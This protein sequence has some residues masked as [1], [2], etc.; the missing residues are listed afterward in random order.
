[1]GV[2]EELLAQQPGAAAGGSGPVEQEDDLGFIGM[3]KGYVPTRPGYGGPVSPA[4]A[5]R[6]AAGG[7]TR[8]PQITPPRYKTGAE[9]EPRSYSPEMIARLQQQL[10]GAGLI[11]PSTRYRLGVWD[12]TSVNAYKQLLGYA[13]Q[14]GLSREDALQQLLT[15]PQLKG[16]QAVGEDGVMGGGGSAGPQVLGGQLRTYEASDPASVRQTAEAAFRQALGRKPK[17][18]EL[19]KF[20]SQFLGQERGA[21][22]VVFKAQDRLEAKNLL[23]Q[24][25]AAAA[26]GDAAAAGGGGGEA[27]VLWDRMQQLIADAPGK[28]TPGKRTRS[29]EEQVRLYERYKAGKGPLAAKPGTSKHGDGRANDLKYENQATKRWVLQNA[30]RYGLSFPLLNAGEDWHIQLKD[31]HSQSDGHDHG[32]PATTPGGTIVVGDEQVTVQRQDL[33]AQAVEY[34]RN[35][36]PDETAAYDIGQQFNSFLSILSKGVV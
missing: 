8:E 4:Q 21:Q 36:N 32:G 1:M 20:V 19:D 9:M 18:D 15:A 35:V 17:K 11:G 30:E 12:S 26:G 7:R 10:A 3:P 22:D 27:D 5:E 31:G 13:N 33:G 23:A 28:V 25:G 16:A 24:E 6:L 2:L 29:Y 34:A 14:G